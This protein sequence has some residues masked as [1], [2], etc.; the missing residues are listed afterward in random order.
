MLRAICIVIFYALTK[1]VRLCG[2][3]S[4]TA[5]Q[6]IRSVVLIFKALHGS[7]PGYIT[8]MCVPVVMTD[9]RATLRSASV[10]ATA[11]TAGRLTEP[12]RSTKTLY[13]ERAFAVAGPAVWNS[14][15]ADIRLTN[16][17]DSFKKQLIDTSF[18]HIVE[19]KAPLR[20]FFHVTALYKLS[21][22]SSSSSCT[23]SV[24]LSQ[25]LSVHFCLLSI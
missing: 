17:F 25:C 5:L 7:A 20:R 22:S 8:Q 11:Y 6:T 9:R 12:K 24:D 14:L 15:P 16:C 2:M 10:S 23:Q 19:C 1:L 21:N 18:L 3:I 13:S 4:T